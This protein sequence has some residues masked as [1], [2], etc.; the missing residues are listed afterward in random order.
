M[1]KLELINMLR[2]ECQV[3]KKE[4]ASVVDLFSPPM[5]DL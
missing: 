3:S 4:T 1:N 2:D 5:D